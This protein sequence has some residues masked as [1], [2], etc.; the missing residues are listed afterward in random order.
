MK[1]RSLL[2]SSYRPL[3]TIAQDIRKDWKN[4]SPYAKPYLDAMADLDKVTDNYHHDTGS[5][6]VLY[7]LSNAASWKGEN[8]KRIK[9]EL[10]AMV[11][12]KPFNFEEW[13]KSG[14]THSLPKNLLIKTESVEHEKLKLDQ[15][16]VI[17]ADG[18]EIL[19]GPFTT[20]SQA[21]LYYMSHKNEKC[22][23]LTG[24][25]VQD[26]LG[27]CVIVE[28]INFAVMQQKIYDYVLKKLKEKNSGMHVSYAAELARTTDQFFT[29]AFDDAH[30]AFNKAEDKA[31]VE[32]NL[33]KAI[34]AVGGV[35]VDF[36]AD[37]MNHPTGYAARKLIGV[38]YDDPT[39]EE[40]EALIK[41]IDPNLD[42]ELADR[43]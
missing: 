11:A 2:E 9:A 36:F 37:E 39:D 35:I 41:K 6:V 43:S 29:T 23:V 34:E 7:F 38:E 20:R 18:K 12:N 16:Y 24:A 15:F 28:G 14:K 25:E 40:I 26:V 31:E 33:R 42:K 17:S 19:D 27:E 3:S 30:N 4:I 10:K 13:Q 32:D 1:I 22:K 21:D 5:S 8:A